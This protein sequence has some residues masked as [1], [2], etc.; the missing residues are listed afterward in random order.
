M[1]TK[2]LKQLI[3]ESVHEVIKEE[4]SDILKEAVLGN[5][6]TQE[7]LNEEQTSFKFNSN[8]VI[9]KPSNGALRSKLNEIYGINDGKPKQIP[10]AVEAVVEAVGGEKNPFAAMFAQ[11]AVE[12]TPADRANLSRLD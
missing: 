10:K 8:D 1:N 4:L 11:T 7:F 9:T 6:K 12:M 2:A 3:K 5:R